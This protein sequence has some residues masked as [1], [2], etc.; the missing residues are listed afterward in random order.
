[1]KTSTLTKGG[2]ISVPADV[3]RR[4]GARRVLIEDLGDALVVRP[5]PEDPIGAA[6]G[7]LAG[8]GPTS[9]E[10]RAIVRDEEREREDRSRGPG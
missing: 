8:P 3:R 10:A 9:D 5:L 4:W 6:M 7:S 2:Q 1:M